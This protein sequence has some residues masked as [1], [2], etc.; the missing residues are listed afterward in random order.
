[1]QRYQAA[2]ILIQ[3]AF[4]SGGPIREASPP[5]CHVYALLNLNVNAP[6]IKTS[7]FSG[8]FTFTYLVKGREH[9]SVLARFLRRTYP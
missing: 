4:V 1:M 7:R 2:S 8:V 5:C 3:K 9:S 6:E